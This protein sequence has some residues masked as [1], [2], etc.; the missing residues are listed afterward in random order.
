MQF[1]GTYIWIAWDLLA[2]GIIFHRVRKC[3]GMGFVSTI[4]RLLIYIV[5]VAA[6]HMTYLKLADFLYDNV[7]HDVIQSTLVRSFNNMINGIGKSND[8]VHS[9]P[10]ALRIL[11]GLKIGEV[12][13]IPVTDASGMAGQV[14][15]MALKQPIISI[16][17]GVGFLLI[18]TLTAYIMRYIARLFTEINRVPVIGTLNAVLGGIAGV[19]EGLLMLF[20]SGFIMRIAIEVSGEVWW[21]LNSG[22]IENTYIWRLFY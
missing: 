12:A 19:V 17:H 8:I 20:V 9:I 13:D 1:I 18:F 5:A 16:L 10:T 11:I 7:I 21:W 4:I 3:A 6:A 2:A 22:V 15:E 14:I